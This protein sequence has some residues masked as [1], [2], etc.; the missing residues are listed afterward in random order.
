MQLKRKAQLK[1]LEEQ[2]ALPESNLVILY[3]RKGIGKTTLISQFLEGKAAAYYYEGKE[4]T[5]GL[6]RKLAY[7]QMDIGAG[8]TLIA[9]YY[10]MFSE[11]IGDR[12]EKAVIVLDEFHYIAKN[13]ENFIDALR[14]LA[15]GSNPLMFVLCSSS[16][17]WV[18]N[19]MV[20]YLGSHASYIT[21]YIK[22]K[23]LTFVDFV[24]YFPNSSVETCIRINAILGG[25]LQYLEGWEEDRPPEY[26][27]K[28]L[29]L[30]KNSSLF[31]EPEYFLKLELREPAVYNTILSALAQG[32]RKL[33]DIHLETGFSRAKI[34]VYLKHL[35]QLDLVEKLLPLSDEGKENVQKGLYRIKDNFMS[36][37]Y[38]FI[39][40]NRSKLLIGDMDQFYEE[41]IAPYIE[42]YIS[43]YFADVCAEYLKLLNLH[44]RLPDRFL[45]WDRW[46]GKNG[47]IDILSKS[48]KGKTLVGKCIWTESAAGIAEYEELLALAKTAG[49]TPDYIYL[50]SKGGFSKELKDYSIN[51]KYITLVSLGDL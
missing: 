14:L 15:D 44:E 46:Y 17:R 22:L 30:N 1:L 40:P 41:E 45:W 38:R 8:E 18:E 3:G 25:V 34:I 43:E 19:E 9:D 26:N 4:C 39:F 6:Q 24:S 11:F 42:E 50:F 23:E 48:E 36:F 29:L 27:I 10:R 13:S 49:N 21:T 47:V 5:D 35:M 28:H 12:E 7:G 37:W 2:Y 20:S 32:K 16:V 51:N 33:N 31:S